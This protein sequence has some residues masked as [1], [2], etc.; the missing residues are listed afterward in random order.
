MLVYGQPGSDSIP[1]CAGKA[2]QSVRDANT[3]PVRGEP[4]RSTE[5]I[6]CSVGMRELLCT[7]RAELL[8]L[9]QLFPFPAESSSDLLVLC[10]SPVGCSGSHLGSALRCQ[11][12]QVPQLGRENNPRFQ[13]KTIQF[14]SI[15]SG[16][17]NVGEL[18]WEWASPTE[19]SS[20][21]SVIGSY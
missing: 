19:K 8:C 14:S 18:G 3:K 17:Y 5:G 21:Y 4:S 6:L 15:P 12:T 7:V 10:P 16:L 1:D 9:L 2:P 20:K 13:P 11:V